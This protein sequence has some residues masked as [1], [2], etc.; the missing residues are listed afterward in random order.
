MSSRL[1]TSN[2]NTRQTW[3]PDRL[4]GQVD[5][6]QVLQCLEFSSQ[7]TQQTPVRAQDSGFDE[8]FLC[9]I[10]D[11]TAPAGQRIPL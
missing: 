9:K 5:R 10:A 2:T 7:S 4:Q 1:W 11:F 6:L 3:L 8:N